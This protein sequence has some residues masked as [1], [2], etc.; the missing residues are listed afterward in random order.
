MKFHLLY[1]NSI[2]GNYFIRDSIKHLIIY[3]F[4][5]FFVLI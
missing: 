3:N 4:G 1:S 5:E 2:L